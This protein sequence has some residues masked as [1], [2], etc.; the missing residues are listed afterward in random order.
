MEKISQSLHSQTGFRAQCCKRC[1]IITQIMPKSLVPGRPQLAAGWNRDNNPAQVGKCR[2]EH[3]KKKLRVWQVFQHIEQQDHTN[4][5]PKSNLEVEGVHI[6][7]YRFSHRG[8]YD[9]PPYFTSVAV[10]AVLTEMPHDQPWTAANIK[11]DGARETL[12]SPLD[13]ARPCTGPPVVFHP[14]IIVVSILIYR[15]GR[16]RRGR[17]CVSHGL[18]PQPRPHPPPCRQCRPSAPARSARPAPG[19]TPGSPR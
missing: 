8:V 6:R 5:K 10:V 19:R 12:D 15:I 18:S 9:R 1:T 13:D 3:R 11:D 16:S 17:V 2:E 7:L 14:G 4:T